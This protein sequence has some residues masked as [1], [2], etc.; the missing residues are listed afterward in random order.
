[1]ITSNGIVHQGEFGLGWCTK[2]MVWS[3]PMERESTVIPT[4]LD[5]LYG[6]QESKNYIKLSCS[7]VIGNFFSLKIFHVTKNLRFLR[8]LSQEAGR[9]D[10]NRHYGLYIDGDI[11]KLPGG[12]FIQK[13]LFI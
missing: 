4:P 6:K 12:T 2:E 9:A 1:M 8:M 13:Y 10:R 7:K 3:G 11:A 5:C